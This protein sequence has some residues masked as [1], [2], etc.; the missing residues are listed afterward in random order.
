MNETLLH[1]G[2]PAKV[3]EGLN[4]HLHQVSRLPL[5][6]LS[7]AL[8]ESARVTI[9]AFAGQAG[10]ALLQPL[11]DAAANMSAELVR[12]PPSV[13][14]DPAHTVARIRAVISETISPSRL[15]DFADA[16]ITYWGTTNDLVQRQEHGAQKEGQPLDWEDA[17]RVVFH[18]AIVMFEIARAV[19]QR[20]PA[21]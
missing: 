4:Q 19:G 20:R 15:R 6:R 5:Q 10:A 16:L 21:S 1:V 18:T 2:V 11:R 7:D 13:D 3:L 12:P 9:E 8:A 14:P 17:R